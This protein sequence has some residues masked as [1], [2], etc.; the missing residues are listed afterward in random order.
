[1]SPDHRDLVLAWIRREEN[2]EEDPEEVVDRSSLIDSLH[3]VPVREYEA[4]TE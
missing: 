1:M 4:A 2:L 3:Q